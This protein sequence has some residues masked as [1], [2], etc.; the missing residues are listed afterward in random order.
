MV[1]E[2]EQKKKTHEKLPARNVYNTFSEHEINMSD[3][4][5]QNKKETNTASLSNTHA[6]SLTCAQH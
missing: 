2:A 5:E 4:D 6:L 3:E 1:E